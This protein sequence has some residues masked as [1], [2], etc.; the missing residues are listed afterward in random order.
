MN[1]FTT[2]NG[3]KASASPALVDADVMALV[4]SVIRRA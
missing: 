1:R 3:T 2:T 4:P